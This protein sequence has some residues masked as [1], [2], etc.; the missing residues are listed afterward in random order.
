MGSSDRDGFTHMD[1]NKREIVIGIGLPWPRTV[2]SDL[3]QCLGEPWT[4]LRN[5]VKE[6]ADAG[7]TRSKCEV[8]VRRIRARAGLT[9]YD[10]IRKS[11]QDSDVLVFDV[12]AETESSGGAMTCNPNVLFEM[13]LALG[14]GKPVI[15]VGSGVEDWRFLPSDLQGMFVARYR[16]NG[17]KGQPTSLESDSQREDKSGEQSIRSTVQSMVI[18]VAETF[19]RL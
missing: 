1:S 5:I 10:G 6:G 8:N 18:K 2:P 15:L 7:A 3:R 17:S 9:L 13:G 12:S 16:V 4:T 19:S 11:I 14:L